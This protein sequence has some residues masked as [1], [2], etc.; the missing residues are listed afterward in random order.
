MTNLTRA[1][2]KAVYEK[3]AESAEW[4]G[5]HVGPKF[6]HAANCEKCFLGGMAFVL[7]VIGGTSQEEEYQ[8]MLAM[9][10]KPKKK[11]VKKKATKKRVVRRIKK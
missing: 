6:T 2:E 7:S 1:E 4:L 8:A 5:D 3:V 11:I 9:V 10:P